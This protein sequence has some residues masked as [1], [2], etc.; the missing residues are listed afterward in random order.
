MLTA[1]RC[2][3][4]ALEKQG[5]FACRAPL[6]DSSPNLAVLSGTAFF[7]PLLFEPVVNQMLSNSIV[8]WL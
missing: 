3:I 8:I 2:G 5:G 7:L 4:V 1:A 6:L